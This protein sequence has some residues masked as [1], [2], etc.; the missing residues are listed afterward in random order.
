MEARRRCSKTTISYGT[1]KKM[2]NWYEYDVELLIFYHV[3]QGVHQHIW[4]DKIMLSSFLSYVYQTHDRISVY[5]V[6]II[7]HLYPFS[8]HILSLSYHVHQTDPECIDWLSKFD[9]NNVD[10]LKIWMY[11][12]PLNITLLTNTSRVF[13][14]QMA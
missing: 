10:S 8:N 11:P 7:S 12:P 6:T 14:L 2:D 9:V 4:Y 1:T 5:H 13:T 3:R